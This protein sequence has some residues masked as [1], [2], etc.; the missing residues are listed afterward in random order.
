MTRLL[1]FGIYLNECT[2][3]E[4]SSFITSKLRLLRTQIGFD[5]LN[6]HLIQEL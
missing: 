4:M 6:S 2:K 3:E 5:V 1:K